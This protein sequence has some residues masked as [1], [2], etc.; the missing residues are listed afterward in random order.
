M[1][2]DTAAEFA[3]YWR[4]LAPG[5]A[6]PEPEYRFHSARRWRFDWAFPAH[7]VA[8]EIDGGGWLAR[9]GRH[10]G[11]GDRQKLNAAAELGWLVLRY[12]PAMLRNDP[13]GVVRQVAETLQRRDELCKA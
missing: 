3:A 4:Q 8:V 11:D 9:G 6:A 2:A 5:L 10:A 1:A 13:L 12:S 7:L